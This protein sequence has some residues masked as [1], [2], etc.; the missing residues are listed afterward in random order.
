MDLGSSIDCVV[1]KLISR[2]INHSTL[3]AGSGQPQRESVRVMVTSVAPLSERCP[4]KF[5]QNGSRIPPYKRID[6]SVHYVFDIGRGKGD[7]GLSIFNLLGWTNTWY[8]QYD[9][10]QDPPLVTEINY[11]GRTP[12][13]SINID[14]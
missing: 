11:L 4:A 12:N 14:F 10:N 8:Y 1:A 7:I 6:I 13:L 9:F 3:D 2:P 5:A